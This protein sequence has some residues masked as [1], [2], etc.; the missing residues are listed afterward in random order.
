MNGFRTGGTQGWRQRT[1]LGGLPVLLHH[2]QDA[3]RRPRVRPSG[4]KGNAARRRASHDVGSQRTEAGRAQGRLGLTTP[5]TLRA[6]QEGEDLAAQAEELLKRRHPSIVQ[7]AALLPVKQGQISG[8]PVSGT[9]CA[10][11]DRI[12]SR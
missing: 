6:Q 3:R 1:H 8:W 4:E 5:R 7:L 9:V 12:R 10:E 2:A 11:N